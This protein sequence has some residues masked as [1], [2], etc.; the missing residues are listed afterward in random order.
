MTILTISAA[1][2]AAG[3]DRRTLQRAIKAGRLSATTSAAGAR[4]IDVAELIRVF[5]PLRQTP[6]AVAPG[7]RAAM[8]QDTAAA[9]IVG[10]LREQVQQIQE[11]LRQSQQEKAQL[12]DML[13]AEQQAR[14]EL[15]TRLLLAPKKKKKGG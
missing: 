2:Q 12:L 3:I 6:P 8:S 7:T 10:L 11:Q 15:E 5:G 4:G 13:Q 9:E 14:R 1:A